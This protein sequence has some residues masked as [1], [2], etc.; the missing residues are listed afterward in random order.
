[1][2]RGVFGGLLV[3]TD[4]PALRWTDEECAG[5]HTSGIDPYLNHSLESKFFSEQ[6]IMASFYHS[7]KVGCMH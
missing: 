3:D 2:S 5:P 6:L 4:D 7:Y 1:M